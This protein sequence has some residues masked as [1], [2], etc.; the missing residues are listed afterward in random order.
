MIQRFFGK[1]QAEG[2]FLEHIGSNFH[3]SVHQAVCRHQ[4]TDEADFLGLFCIH[5]PAG[6]QNDLS[7]HKKCLL[8]SYTEGFQ[9]QGSKPKGYID[10]FS[11]KRS[12][13]VLFI[14]FSI[15][16]GLL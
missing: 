9:V 15:I 5:R 16:G 4:S 7:E 6:E 8:Y 1:T 11:K 3:C 2:N 10:L 12:I 13:R 14:I